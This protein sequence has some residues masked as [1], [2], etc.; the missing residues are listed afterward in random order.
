MTT[1]NIQSWLRPRHCAYGIAFQ[2][3][4]DWMYSLF[5]LFW[6]QNQGNLGFFFNNWEE[7]VMHHQVQH[8][9][10]W[11]NAGSLFLRFMKFRSMHWVLNQIG[12]PFFSAYSS[13]FSCERS[14]VQSLKLKHPVFLS[15]Y[16][17]MYSNT[18]IADIQHELTK[19]LYF[20]IRKD[21]PHIS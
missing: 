9:G 21:K 19:Q 15:L 17:Q 11:Y 6:G 3:L 14:W 13:F 1:E 4:V 12:K 7:R 16:S 20:F 5:P 8:N 18:V 2:T 10:N